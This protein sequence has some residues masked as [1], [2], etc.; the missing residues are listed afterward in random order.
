MTEYRC[1]APSD[2]YEPEIACQAR[3]VSPPPVDTVVPRVEM[4]DAPV[5]TDAA[6][7]LSPGSLLG[8]IRLT[9]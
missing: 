3:T 4:V 5:D 2:W 1:S 8:S 9:V 6:S 7:I